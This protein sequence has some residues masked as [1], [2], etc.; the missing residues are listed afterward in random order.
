MIESKTE[1]TFETVN[2]QSAVDHKGRGR[3]KSLQFYNVMRLFR[4]R[5]L[6]LN[7]NDTCIGFKALI[8]VSIKILKKEANTTI[9]CFTAFA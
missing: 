2:L 7:R 5:L 9:T 4:E 3:I 8:K 6:S 1:F